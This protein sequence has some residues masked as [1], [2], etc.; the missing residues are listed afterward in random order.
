M[1]LVPRERL[2]DLENGFLHLRFMANRIATEM[3]QG[4]AP[5]SLAR[6]LRKEAGR[7]LTTISQWREARWKIER[8]TQ[9]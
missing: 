6:L 2:D 1:I 9:P 7:A 8:S 5:E 4:A 3:Q